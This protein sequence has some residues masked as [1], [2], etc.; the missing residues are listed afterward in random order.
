MP[1]KTE[2]ATWLERVESNRFDAW[3]RE[4]M[5]SEMPR[6][7]FLGFIPTV[8]AFLQGSIVDLGF[9]NLDLSPQQTRDIILAFGGTGVV[10]PGTS[11]RMRFVYPHAAIEPVDGS[12]AATLPTWWKEGVLVTNDQSV[13]TW[14][15]KRVRPDQT[16]GF[17]LTGY[18]DVGE[19]L[20]P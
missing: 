11:L 20:I 4:R 2:T 18:T 3:I 5:I 7:T 6:T 10:I 8:V 15:G 17:D 16:A 14:V 13:L 9:E 19:A 12:E 1:V